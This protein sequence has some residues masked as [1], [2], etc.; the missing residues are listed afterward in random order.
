LLTSL[1]NKELSLEPTSKAI[2]HKKYHS[3]IYNPPIQ[4]Y[5]N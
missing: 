5:P 3:A 1:H 2:I 4:N